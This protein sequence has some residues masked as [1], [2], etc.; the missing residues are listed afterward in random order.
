MGGPVRVLDDA[1]G[2]D[3]QGEQLNRHAQRKQRVA[4]VE[5]RTEK[6]GNQW[7]DFVQLFMK[8]KRSAFS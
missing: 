4:C 8:S 6:P 1:A 5:S 3:K 7:V 2:L